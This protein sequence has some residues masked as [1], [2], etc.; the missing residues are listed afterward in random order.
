VVTFIRVG[1]MASPLTK[2]RGIVVCF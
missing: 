1:L 2:Q